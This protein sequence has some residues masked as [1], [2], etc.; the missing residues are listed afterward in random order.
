MKYAYKK[1]S[2]FRRRVYNA[3]YRAKK[4]KVEGFFTVMTIKNLYVKQ[5]GK[6]AICENY[7]CG[8]FEADHILPLSKGGSNKPSNI[9]LVCPKCNKEK[10]CKTS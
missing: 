6:C 2:P 4:Y 8:K 5:R 1:L 3:R 10:G 7:L 9:Q